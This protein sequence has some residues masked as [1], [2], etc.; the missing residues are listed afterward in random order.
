MGRKV[1]HRCYRG[2][3]MRPFLRL[4]TSVALSLVLVSACASS[5]FDGHVYRSEDLSFKV[6]PV[7]ANWRSVSVEGTRLAFRDDAASA[8]V[9]VN[10]RCGV[11]G[12]DVPLE[13]LT[14]HLFLHFTG[15]TMQKQERLELDGRAA[16]RSEL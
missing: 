13:A 9:E 14:H 1:A 7:P 8:T 10:G 11:D 3:G 4:R 12:D 16:L 5:G 6:G 15:R 2:P